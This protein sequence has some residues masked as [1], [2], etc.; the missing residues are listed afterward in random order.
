MKLNWNFQRGGGGE[1]AQ[2]IQATFCGFSKEAKI[3]LNHPVES[4]FKHEATRY[5]HAEGLSTSIKNPNET[6]SLVEKSAGF[7]FMLTC[8]D[9]LAC[10]ISG[11]NFYCF[12]L[13]ESFRT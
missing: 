12:T 9:F 5:E 11:L 2:A 8:S 3:F 13:A 4:D 7:F 6:I 1:G 10:L